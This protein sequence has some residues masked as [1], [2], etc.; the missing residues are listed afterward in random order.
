MITQIKSIE[1]ISV[2]ICILLTFGVMP[3]SADVVIT[4]SPQLA[5]DHGAQWHITDNPNIWYD[6][7]VSVTLPPG[8]H[9]IEFKDLAD[10]SEPLPLQIL[11]AGDTLQTLNTSYVALT[12]LPIGQ[13]P[14]QVVWQDQ[15]LE[16]MVCLP[17]V[18]GHVLIDA[19]I[20]AQLQPV[21]I[22]EFSFLPATEAGYYVLRYTPA[23][24]DRDDFHVILEGKSSELPEKVGQLVRV[25]PMQILADETIVFKTGQHAEMIS[26]PVAI[27]K[28]EDVPS[29]SA[30]TFNYQTNTY[31]R[32]VSIEGDRIEISR[33]NDENYLY[34]QLCAV[35]DTSGNTINA[36]IKALEIIADVL[37]IKTRL[38][39][40][41]TD[42]TIKAVELHFEDEDTEV[43]ACIVTTPVE[44]EDGPALLPG[45]TQGSN[46]I[47]GL[48]AGDIIIDV[49]EFHNA[50]LPNGSIPL[51]FIL[52]GG[53]GQTAGE[54]RNGAAGPTLPYKDSFRARCETWLGTDKFNT[55]TYSSPPYKITSVIYN[56]HADGWDFDWDDSLTG[57]SG[58]TV[59]P[60]GENA[61]AGGLPGAGGDSGHLECT[62]PAEYLYS[63]NAGPKGRR[64]QTY[65]GGQRGEPLYYLQVIYDLYGKV[66]GSGTCY[67]NLGFWGT[68]HVGNNAYP[69]DDSTIP[70]GNSG[71]YQLIASTMEQ[72]TPENFNQNLN[73]IRQF[74]LANQIDVCTEKIEKYIRIIDLFK[75]RS[76][77]DD[78]PF[79][80]KCR[81]ETIY[82]NLRS[83]Q[84]RIEN[85]LDYY[86]NPAGWVPKLSL[87]VNRTIFDNEI[88]RAINML[89]LSYW[90]KEEA[91]TAQYRVDA[92]NDTIENLKSE[93][94]T[95][96]QQY[97]KAVDSLPDMETESVFLKQNTE[98]VQNKLIYREEQLRQQAEDNLREPWWKTGLKIAGSICNMIPV[99][100]PALGAIGGGMTLAANF[101]ESDPWATIMGAA[102]ITTTMASS[103]LTQK[104][105][106]LKTDLSTIDPDFA[107]EE[108]QNTNFLSML[109]ENSGPVTSAFSQISDIVS[110]R[111]APKS[112][113]D[114]E[115][116]R[117]AAEDEEFQA[118]ADEINELLDAKASLSKKIASAVQAISIVPNQISTNIQAISSFNSEKV[119]TEAALSNEAVE[120]LNALENRAYDRLIKYHYYLAKSYEYR[121]LK[122]YTNP[123]DLRSMFDKFKDIAQVN[124]SDDHVLQPDQ[125]A[126]VKAIYED[127]LSG[128]AEE[129]FDQ[130]IQ[131]ASPE[132]TITVRFNLSTEELDKINSG[133]SLTLNLL[134]IGLFNGIYEENLR[135][136]DFSVYD[137]SASSD[138]GI[139]GD[140]AYVDLRIEHPGESKIKSN[141]TVY[142]FRFSKG[143]ESRP[144]EWGCRY[145]LVDQSIEGIRPSAASESLLRS[146][147]EGDAISDMML[148]SRPSAWGDLKLSKTSLNSIRTDNGVVTRDNINIQSVRLELTYDFVRKNTNLAE[149]QVGVVQA[150][151]QDDRW[152]TTS[153]HFQPYCTVSR[154]DENDRQDGR[155]QFQ[156]V[157]RKSPSDTVMF[158]AQRVYGKWM[159]HSWV[160]QYGQT[161]P[162]A[163]PGS[164]EI[165][166]PMDSDNTIFAMYVS[167]ETLL[168]DLNADGIVNLVDFT[169]FGRFFGQQCNSVQFD[170]ADGTRT[171]DINDLSGFCEYW[172]MDSQTT[173]SAFESQMQIKSAP[174]SQPSNDDIRSTNLREIDIVEIK[175]TQK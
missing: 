98:V 69:P 127:I 73:I 121:L 158:S 37:V 124:S 169:L 157:Y 161:V 129:I 171:I 33:Y 67:T 39:L 72:F 43:P 32:S 40:P 87:E 79:V 111:E 93:I 172:L 101:D 168:A 151:R 123:L 41:G 110:A 165:T 6:P 30:D 99:Y 56:D 132:F 94:T 91:D 152:I 54:G 2:V 18:D 134:D 47:E 117:L 52:D 51:R 163:L 156:R 4:I 130:Y 109:S 105:Q 70:N 115:L 136:V 166:L 125:F 50:Q 95:L 60:H 29:V 118:L 149:F 175:S 5:V 14:D 64:A 74:Y 61:V 133:K 77:W 160:D 144:I 164:T 19:T 1:I 80:R 11:D 46:G 90:L 139:L 63:V 20:T 86:G 155:G 36:D 102:D 35:T 25:T 135:I 8:M 66:F 146:L 83:L 58:S 57:W 116:A 154:L 92:L 7:N 108:Q 45:S 55:P 131:N 23:G 53:Q 107:D 96:K 65:Y 15:T 85:G 100:Q 34:S 137:I 88:D 17:D 42:V 89:Y 114:A 81:I 76:D 31:P 84:N 170:S 21:P 103:K 9:T 10:W 44:L 22:G 26:G 3:S 145:D 24:D 122:P 16:L 173:H 38:W 128:I 68:A 148:Y 13:I 138:D 174:I 153:S 62:M 126:S 82:G 71:T 113:I 49:L 120:Y 12:R 140:T 141:G 106:K 48:D 59:L 97:D 167:R 143:G 112:E 159:F 162:G 142:L 78:I 147:L 27:R 75:Q 119:S 28:N 104:S 150:Q